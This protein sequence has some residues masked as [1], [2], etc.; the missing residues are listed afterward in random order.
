[1]SLTSKV[2]AVQE[3]LRPVRPRGLPRPGAVPVP[4]HR[5]RRALAS[6]RRCSRARST[7]PA[8]AAVIYE[9]VQGEGGFL[10][11]TRASS[12]ASSSSAAS[13]ASSTSTTRCSPAC[14]APATRPAIEHCRASSPTS[15]RG[16]SRMGGGMPLAGVTGR[17]NHGRRHIR[18]PRR[19]LRRQPHL[20]RGRHRGARP[21]ARSGV[22]GGRARLGDRLRARLDDSPAVSPPSARCAVSA[23]C[24]RSSWWRTAPASAPAAADGRRAWS[25]SP[26]SAACC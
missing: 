4:R 12:R 10:P 21:G 1:M 3:G 26:A 9:P 7:P 5:H 22:P 24:W 2:D 14:A 11:A 19:H 20:L 8:V 15:A 17:P 6:S 23:R 13:T 25:S 16:A 18:R